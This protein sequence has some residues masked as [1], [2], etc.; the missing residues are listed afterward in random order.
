MKAW[1]VEIRDDPDQGAFVA[2]ADTRNQARA[3]ADRHDLMYESWIDISATRFKAMDGKEHLDKA[4]LTLE[5]WRDHC[6]RWW[7]ISYPDQDEA[8]DEEFLDWYERTF[9]N[10]LERK[11]S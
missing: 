3:Q 7:D 10:N 11:T 5:L 2:F 6:W 4:H 8:T 9:G 1:Y